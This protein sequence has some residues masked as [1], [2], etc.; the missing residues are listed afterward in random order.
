M[1]LIIHE[2]NQ[3]IFIDFTLFIFGGVADNSLRIGYIMSD[4]F[5]LYEE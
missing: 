2:S 3:F 1:C 4:A 5:I